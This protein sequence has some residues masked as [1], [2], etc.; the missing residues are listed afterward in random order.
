MKRIK[1][2]TLPVVAGVVSVQISMLFCFGVIVGYVIAKCFSSKTGSI[3]I[4]LG[5]YKIHLHHWLSALI[6]LSIVII[7]GTYVFFPMFAL[8]FG[9]GF[10]LQGIHCYNDWYQILKKR[11]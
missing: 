1:K 10:L 7:S 4:P 3:Q 2:I 11:A 5:K 6:G 9:V 8:G